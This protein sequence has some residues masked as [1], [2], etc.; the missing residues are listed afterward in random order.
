M[1][2]ALALAT[3][4]AHAGSAPLP[5]LTYD[6]FA[7]SYTRTRLERD[8]ASDYAESFT[9]SGSL[10]LA[11]RLHVWGWFDKFDGDYS[12]D[13]RNPDG[14]VDILQSSPAVDATLDGFAV[15]AG[16]GM[17][18]DVADRV[19]AYARVGLVRAESDVEIALSPIQPPSDDSTDPIY[20]TGLRFNAGP[21]WELFGGIS[22]AD[23]DSAGHA[24]AE[25]RI[26]DGWGTQFAT[27]LGEDATGLSVCVVRR[28]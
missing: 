20:A 17:H 13:L 7:L 19:S 4:A 9:L 3:D 6:S 24:G 15:A 10:E 18:H 25:F 11:D 22:H 14:S 1:G 26:G 27:I 2:L 12:L 23:G 16:F 8:R 28:F 5:G 21:R